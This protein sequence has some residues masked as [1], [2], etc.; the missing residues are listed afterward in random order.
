MLPGLFW[1]EAPF[2]QIWAPIEGRRL[3]VIVLC[4]PVGKRPVP[5]MIS[6]AADGVTTRASFLQEKDAAS[7]LLPED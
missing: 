6:Y 3:S 4:E 2:R 5:V 7:R 1:L